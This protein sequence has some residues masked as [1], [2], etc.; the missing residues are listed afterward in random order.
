LECQGFKGNGYLA[1]SHLAEHG[2]KK[3]DLSKFIER[4]VNQELLRSL[5]Q[6]IRA[7]NAQI[8]GEALQA[9]IDEECAEGRK[10]F[11]KDRRSW[12]E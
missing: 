12:D 2:G 7:Q 5:I 8:P 4:A 1:G 3:G 10:E 6:E 11:W 9:I